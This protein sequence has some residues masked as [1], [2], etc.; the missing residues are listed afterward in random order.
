[1]IPCHFAQ[2]IDN[3]NQPSKSII[4]KPI[5]NARLIHTRYPP[6]TR[7]VNRDLPRAIGKGDVG[8]PIQSVVEI[9]RGVS[10]AVSKGDLIPV[11]VVAIEIGNGDTADTKR[12]GYGKP[13][14]CRIVGKSHD[15]AARINRLR[16]PANTVINRGAGCVIRI[17][18]VGETIQCV[19][20]V[21]G[22]PACAIRTGDAIAGGIVGGRFR[23]QVG[24]GGPD[25]PALCIIG[26][27]SCPAQLVNGGLLL[28]NGVIDNGVGPAIGIN[29]LHD[30]VHGIIDALRNGGGPDVVVSAPDG[31]G[32]VIAVGVVGKGIRA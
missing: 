19:V 24:V 22:R 15:G 6:A 20:I 17:D 14:A 13:L 2:R 23:Y 8:L 29:R 31:G 26:V 5:G 30:A 7:V 18:G 27:A 28:A 9:C 11:G 25:E 1:M 10:Q 3:K 21:T 12:I 32:E 16:H 4:N